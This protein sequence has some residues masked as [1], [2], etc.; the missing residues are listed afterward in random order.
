MMLKALGIQID[1]KLFEQMGAAVIEIRDRLAR[2]EVQN[3]NII[4]ILRSA[5]PLDE[6]ERGDPKAQPWE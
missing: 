5:E 1:P 4:A 3:Q 6:L 2:I